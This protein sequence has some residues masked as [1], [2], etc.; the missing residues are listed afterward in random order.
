[1]DRYHQIILGFDGSSCAE[2]AA[3]EAMKI[4]GWSV[5]PL[6][7]YRII[8]PT[9]IDDLSTSTDLDE[10]ACLCALVHQD[11]GVLDTIATPFVETEWHHYCCV[12]QPV[13]VLQEKVEAHQADLMVIGTHGHTHQETGVLGPIARA[14]LRQPRCDV[15]V[16]REVIVG[17]FCHVVVVLGEGT[18]EADAAALR[19]AAAIAAHGGCSL[20]VISC[21]PTNWQRILADRVSQP[22]A[23]TRAERA[24]AIRTTALQKLVASE[25]IP[26]DTPEPEIRVITHHSSTLGVLEQLGRAEADLVV[27]PA[28]LSGEIP[29]VERVVSNTRSSVLLTIHPGPSPQSRATRQAGRETCAAEN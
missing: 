19:R 26:R 29:D 20:Q 6:W 1:M 4:A 22:A 9:E 2:K 13:D 12:G 7:S 5:A 25:T 8:S 3:R 24:V 17:S 10:Q 27:L 18:N 16:V 15:L 21:Y 23:Q 28:Y 11:Y 14:I